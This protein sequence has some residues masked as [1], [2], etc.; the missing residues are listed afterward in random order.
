MQII[1]AGTIDVDPKQRDAAIEKG[2]AL[3]EPTRAQK[4]CHAYYFLPDTL[5]A[6]RICV[7]ERWENEESLKAHFDGP[8]YPAMRD[9]LA[10]FDLRGADVQK[11]RVDLAEPVYDPT[12]VPRADFFTA[13]A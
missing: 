7:Y 11:F 1:I 3:L 5:V 2:K 4:G 13:D 6:G 10:E 9:L 12:G 8:H